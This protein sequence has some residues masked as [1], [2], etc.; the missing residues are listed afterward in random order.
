MSQVY[1]MGV[2]I[3]ESRGGAILGA[4]FRTHNPMKGNA[5]IWVIIAVVIVA[6]LAWFVFGMPGLSKTPATGTS[7]ATE[8]TTPSTTGT[9]SAAAIPGA[10]LTLGENSH[11]GIG[12]FL[13]AYNGM[14]LY[15]YKP[16]TAGVSNCTGSCATNWPPYVVTSAANLVA[17]SPV[18]GAIGTLTR[19]DGS[20]QVTYNGEPLYFYIGDHSPDDIN[21]QGKGGVWYAAKP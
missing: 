20:M 1:G 3:K 18:K 5:V 7:S 14:T 15:T 17:E 6:G 13:V 10:N 4:L 2:L 16:D 9:S 8:P 12:A 11:T 19:A 21:G